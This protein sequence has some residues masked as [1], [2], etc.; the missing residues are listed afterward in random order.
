MANEKNNSGG[1]TLTRVLN[2]SRETV[3]RAFTD[4]AQF[5]QWWPPKDFDNKVF[6]FDL[7]QGGYCHFGM[8][9]RDFSMYARFDFIEIVPPEKIIFT[10]VFTNEHAEPVRNPMDAG[11]PMEMLHVLLL[12]E[13]KGK[14][15]LTLNV[16]AHNATE[17]EKAVFAE[18]FDSMRG[19][20]GSSFDELEKL[21]S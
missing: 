12:S 19:G 9:M 7:K 17:A 20:Y 16:S 6:S 8:F 14:T 2:A 10:S 4:P 1:L 3:Y 5:V 11:W 15:T 18:G 21:I 13:E